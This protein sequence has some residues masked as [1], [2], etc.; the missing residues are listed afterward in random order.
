MPTFVWKGRTASGAMASGELAA[1]S[2]ADV[3][4][5]LR[6][7]KIIPTSIKVKEEKKGSCITAC[8]VCFYAAVLHHAQCRSAT[9]NLS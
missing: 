3:V 4:S 8:V 5:A 9:F 7:K 2:Q 1:G 6:Q